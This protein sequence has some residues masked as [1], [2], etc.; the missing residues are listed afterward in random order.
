[1]FDEVEGNWNVHLNGAKKML[2]SL[3]TQRRRRRL[4]SEF[5]LTWFLYHEVLGCFTQPLRA[6]EDEG[7]I[8]PLVQASVSDA[9]LVSFF[10]LCS[11]L[12]DSVL[13]KG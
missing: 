12:H 11:G 8:L 7:D 9:T 6:E 10:S 4:D 13:T 3:Y 5:T 1:M 2:Q